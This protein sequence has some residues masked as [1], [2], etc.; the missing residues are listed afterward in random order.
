MAARGRCS[1]LDHLGIAVEH[2]LAATPGTTSGGARLS[3][4]FSVSRPPLAL[5]LPFAFDRGT[6]AIGAALRRQ[7][8]TTCP[9]ASGATA[10]TRLAGCRCRFGLFGL[11]LLPLL[12]FLGEQAGSR[13]FGLLA[14]ALFRLAARL[15][16]FL[17][18][19]RRLFLDGLALIF[20]S[21]PA[22]AFSS[23][24]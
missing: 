24:R 20:L 1:A 22:R 5:T 18:A 3:P 19:F 12:L 13:L 23:A 10:A 6:C 9:L 15:F 11:T 17:P 14:R 8:L 16:L 4:R 2:E 21:D 7:R